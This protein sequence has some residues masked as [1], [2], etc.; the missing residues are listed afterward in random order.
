MRL[1]TTVLLPCLCLLCHVG[2]SGLPN[3]GFAPGAADPQLAAQLSQMTYP[4]DEAALG[5]DLRVYAVRDGGTLVLD[6][7]TAQT[8]SDVQL[9]VNQQWVGIIDELP[10]G[11]NNRYDLDRF[12]NEHGETYP[13]G[14]WLSPDKAQ[15]M[16]LVELVDPQTGKRHR[17]VVRTER[18][19]FF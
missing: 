13:T 5:E 16:V 11:T 10:I 19:A 8:F 12:I 2:C 9:W 4:S 15:R 3:V 1:V 7:L 17:L 18:R 6:N 14:S